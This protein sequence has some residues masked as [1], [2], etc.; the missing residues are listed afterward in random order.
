MMVC[1]TF[2]PTTKGRQ[3]YTEVAYPDNAYLV[4][5]REDKGLPEP[6]LKENP[7]R[8]VRLPM[9][10]TLRSLNLS[11]TVAIGAYEVLRQWNFPEMEMEG[12]LH[13]MRWED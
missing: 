13:T 12:E 10:P 4:F 7:S 3:T 5:G 8:C 6:L 2:S 11:N 9:R 1:R